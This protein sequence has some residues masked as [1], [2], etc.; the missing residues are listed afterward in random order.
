MR[1]I[2]ADTSTLSLSL[3]LFFWYFDSAEKSCVNKEN[4]LKSIKCVIFFCHSFNVILFC[5]ST[6]LQLFLQLTHSG[7]ECTGRERSFSGSTTGKLGVR[8]GR[9]GNPQSI[10][11]RTV[12]IWTDG[13]A[14][15]QPTTSAVKNIPSFVRPVRCNY[16][17]KKSKLSVSK[18]TS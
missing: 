2:I 14:I 5:N 13:Q 16:E 8:C 18:N 12:F 7:W 3:S 10:P 15:K 17:E 1:I 6:Y 9:K 11:T 4:Q